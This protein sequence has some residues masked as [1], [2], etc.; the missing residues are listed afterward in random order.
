MRLEDLSLSDSKI[1]DSAFYDKNQLQNKFSN[2]TS[3]SLSK[4]A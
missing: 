1:P 4:T 3:K 2:I